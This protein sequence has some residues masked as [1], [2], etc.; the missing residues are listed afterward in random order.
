M[1][2]R[3]ITNQ[4]RKTFDLRVPIRLLFRE[5]PGQAKRAARKKVSLMGKG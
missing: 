1:Y 4:I 5:R 2:Q 3:Y